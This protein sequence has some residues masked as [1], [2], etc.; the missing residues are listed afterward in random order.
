MLTQ[1]GVKINIM[2][3]SIDQVKL[4][5]NIIQEFDNPKRKLLVCIDQDVSYRPLNLVHLGALRSPC[6]SLDDFKALVGAILESK[7]LSLNSVMGYEA[8]IGIPDN[9]PMNIFMNTIIPFMKNLS[10]SD[11]CKKRAQVVQFLRESNININ[12][13]NGGGTGSLTMAVQDKSISEITVGSAFLHAHL[14]DYYKQKITSPAFLFGLRITRLPQPGVVTCQSGGFIASG[15]VEKLS[16]PSVLLPHG[17]SSD[18]NEGFGEVQTPLHTNGVP[19][20]IG[21]PVFFTP[22]KSGEIAERFNNYLL[23]EN[24][25]LIGEEKTYRGYGKCFY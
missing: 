1:Q 22:A 25:K 17:L 19:L 12:F 11:V 24:G 10:F 18:G 16:A 21:D 5:D 6:R 4:I 8:Q 14:F 9:K 2:V 3:D 7:H 15:P 23:L 20:K 13:F